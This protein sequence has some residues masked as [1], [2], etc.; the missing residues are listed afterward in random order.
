MKRSMM[1]FLIAAILALGAGRAWAH[2]NFRVIGTLTKYANST[3]EVKTKEGRIAKMRVDKQTAISRDKKKVDA[4]E[5]KAGQSV[6]ID[7]YGDSL[8]DSDVLA[9]EIRIVPPI[10]AR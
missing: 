2:D 8:E 10:A 9:I 3:I 4:K 7:A 5:L 1:M 6:V